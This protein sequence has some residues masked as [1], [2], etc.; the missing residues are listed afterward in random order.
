MFPK[1]L[2]D[3]R[4]AI[5]IIAA[6]SLATVI[7]IAALALEYGHA[8]LQRSENQRVADLAAYGGALVYN[9]T[10]SSSS[11]TG[12]AT[13][14]AALNG[15]SSGVSP[16]LVNSPTGD[17]NKAIEVNVTTSVPLYLA[18]VLT[19][20]T[21][22]SVGATAWAEVKTD[23]PGCIVALNN[24][25]TGVSVSGGATVSAPGC[26]VASN[27]TVTTHAC[28]N[29]ITTAVID[30]NSSTAPS[31]SCSFQTSSGGTPPTNKEAVGDP[32]AGNSGVATADARISTVAA[33]TPPTLSSVPSGT[34]ITFDS[35][36]KKSTT[37]STV[38]SISGCS[39]TSTG[40][41][42]VVTCTGTGPFNFGSIAVSGGVSVTINN[43]SSGATYDFSGTIN[44]T[45]SNGLTFNGGSGATYNMGQG[46]ITGGT[47]PITF[48][49]GTFNI[50]GTTCSNGYTYSICLSGGSSLTV[51]GP[52]TFT[53]TSG[54]YQDSSF[55]GA[56]NLGYGTSANSFYIGASNDSTCVP[57]NCSINEANG[58]A[59]FGDA[60]GSGDVFKTA[61]GIDTFGGTCL[62]LSAASQHD[63]NGSLNTAGGVVLG[64]GVWT[65]NGYVAVGNG[66]GG[67]VSNCPT[68]GT[69]TGLTALGV[70]LVVSGVSTTSCGGTT[71]SFCLGAGY[72]TVDITA[73]TSGTTED[74]AVIAPSTDTAAAAFTTGATNTRVS[75]A[76]YFPDA[77]ITM[78]GAA[79]LHD[80]VDAG[81]CL[82]L[83]GSQVTLSNGSAAG[84]T[85]T[86]L[87]ES[88]SGSTVALVQ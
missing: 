29:T 85:C 51:A 39:T 26:A 62:A 53:L 19:T 44:A 10:S 78:T 18:R 80:T 58:T 55:S 48:S 77:P 15:I 33:I 81:A 86:G 46:L 23:A 84:T 30:Y 56:L 45:S 75:G 32:L 71:S 52:S 66:G 42:W 6:L 2:R 9:S 61:N 88:S 83:I 24:A 69:T 50:G 5:S 79:A 25:G 21:S 16:S 47:A 31:L 11:A 8:L 41:P 4:A 3:Q 70:T 65:I 74:L 34:S 40:S 28:T 13:N 12:A 82:Q 76:F 64:A 59:L 17:G 54:I 57:V 20:N 43:S 63:I 67:D 7:G 87:G 14:I 72:S 27:A 36:G 35:G 49:A 60:T 37:A 68:S 38:N 73:P 22:V 1:L